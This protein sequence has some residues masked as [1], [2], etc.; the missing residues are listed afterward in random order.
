MEKLK[1]APKF[2]AL[3][4]SLPAD[5]LSRP[6]GSWLDW[7]NPIRTIAAEFSPTIR[8]ATRQMAQ[9]EAKVRKLTAD[10]QAKRAEI[11]EKWR[12]VAEECTEIQV[13]PRR[14][15]VR[16]THFGLAW[17]PRE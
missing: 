4:A 9:R 2:E 14:T 1:F 15:D 17:V 8:S 7:I 11:T 5:E 10:Y 3:D 6:S 13:K 16:V 12:R